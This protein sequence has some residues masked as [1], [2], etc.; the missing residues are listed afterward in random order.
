ML[1]R[2]PMVGSAFGTPKS[3]RRTTMKTPKKIDQNHGEPAAQRADE[4]A[5]EM[6]VSQLLSQ[7][8]G[9]ANEKLNALEKAIELRGFDL[10]A[11]DAGADDA[12]ATVRAERRALLDERDEWDERKKALRAKIDEALEAE[13]A[14]ATNERWHAI[15]ADVAKIIDRVENGEGLL[16]MAILELQGAQRMGDQL[17]AAGVPKL[18]PGFDP[19]MLNSLI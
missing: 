5:P 3:R 14:Q 17:L 6:P 4:S 7:E 11:L 13:Q 15:R 19:S 1:K 10:L 8:L 2:P 18:P 16:R 9:R 12:R